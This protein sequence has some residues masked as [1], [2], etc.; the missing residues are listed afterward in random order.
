MYE[1][2]SL[3][4]RLSLQKLPEDMTPQKTKT[5]SAKRCEKKLKNE[6]SSVTAETLSGGLQVVDFAETRAPVSK[7][8]AYAGK[9]M[10]K[11]TF[12]KLPSHMR[13]RAMSHNV[14]QLPRRL[15]EN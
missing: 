4:L 11:R 15:K 7:A 5:G 12:Q 3:F 10:G 2:K 8:V 9:E 14:R 1:C 6:P 13:R